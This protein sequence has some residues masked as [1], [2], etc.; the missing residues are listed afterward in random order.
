MAKK[1]N[2]KGM[3]FAIFLTLY[4]L[5]ALGAI[6]YGLYWFWGF[7]GAY[8][9]SRPHI[10]IDKYM[11]SLTPERIVAESDVILEEADLYIQDMEE[12]RGYLMEAVSDE[13]TYARKASACTDT[14]MTYVLR[15]GDR[16]VGSFS[17][18][19]TEADEYGFTPWVFKEEQFD[20]SFLMGT[21][22]IS[23][24]VPKGYTVLVNGVHLDDSYITNRETREYAVL[25]ELYGSYE[26]PELVLYTYE[27]GPFLNAE[28]TMEAYDQSGKPFV[29]DE[30]FDENE[31]IELKDD[32]VIAELDAFVEEFIDIYVIFAGCANDSQYSNY[33]RVMKYVV[34]ESKL[35]KR[36]RDALDGLQFSQSKGDEVADIQINHF[37]GLSE[38]SYLCDVTYKVNTIGHEGEVQTT[39]NAKILIVRKDDKLLVESMIAY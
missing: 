5:V 7:I 34:P 11:A 6:G 35:A 23:I 32:A 37:I 3:G 18:V 27:A 25:E 28:F 31:L 8:E 26:V 12:C 19:S 4:A 29:M 17:I 22:T 30:S 2:R 10:A 15:S 13:I 1:K 16:V 9:A 24:T 33:S 36:M 39:S 20:L 21:D 14:Q 38:D